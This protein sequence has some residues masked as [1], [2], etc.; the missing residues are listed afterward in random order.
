MRDGLRSALVTGSTG[1]LGSALVRQLLSENVEVTCLVRSQSI[2][3]TVQ[4]AGN[5]R[6]RIVEYEGADLE[7]KLRGTSTEYVFNLASYGVQPTERDLDEMIAGNIGI[8]LRVMRA[9]ANWPLRRF[10]HVGS[11]SEYGDP[12]SEGALVAETHPIQPK[13]LYGAAKAASVLWGNALAFSLNVPFVTLRLFGVFGT[14]EGPQRLVPYLISRL[15]DDQSVDLTGGEQVRDFLF[16]D[17][18]ASAF[19]AASTS[20]G[21]KSG[22]VY[23]VCSSTPTR[24][25]DVGELVADAVAKPRGLLHWG[26][27]AYRSD[28]PMWMVGDNRRFRNA[29]GSWCPTT[30]LPAGIRRMVDH[31]RELRKRK[32]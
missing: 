26:E 7:S 30:S 23:N 28:E 22:E 14:Q 12:S 16:E 2:F 17:D 3:K 9:T 27:R 5:P 13:S 29:T 10:V 8:L 18:V 32:K 6:I 31:A 25:R 19:L 20:V 1:F 21:L 15:L 24:I 4:F 11:C